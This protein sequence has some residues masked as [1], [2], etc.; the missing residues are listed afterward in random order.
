MAPN[1]DAGDGGH[2]GERRKRARRAALLLL[3]VALVIYIGF[4]AMSVSLSRQ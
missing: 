3:A 4:I 1:I 2:L